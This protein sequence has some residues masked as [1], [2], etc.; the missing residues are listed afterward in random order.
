MQITKKN[1]IHKIL[2]YLFGSSTA[3]AA[4]HR[5]PLVDNGGPRPSLIMKPSLDQSQSNDRAYMVIV[6]RS[7]INNQIANNA[8]PTIWIVQKAQARPRYLSLD[9]PPLLTPHGMCPLTRVHNVMFKNH[10]L[11]DSYF[12]IRPIPLL[13]FSRECN[14]IYTYRPFRLPSNNSVE[15]PLIGQH[16]TH[17][18]F[19]LKEDLC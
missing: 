2:I 13:N 15:G 8:Q 7:L 16:L 10:R 18:A 9:P 3:S 12:V 14:L 19:Y 17:R 11:S 4:H 5:S 6:D 1:Y